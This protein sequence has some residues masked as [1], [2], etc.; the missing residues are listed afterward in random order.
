MQIQSQ[1]RPPGPQS[2]SYDFISG[3]HAIL[4][5]GDSFSGTVHHIL[6]LA[7]GTPHSARTWKACSPS[8]PIG[9]L[10]RCRVAWWPPGKRWESLP[11]VR[12]VTPKGASLGVCS[13]RKHLGEEWSGKLH[14]PHPGCHRRKPLP[15]IILLCPW[16][17]FCLT[18]RV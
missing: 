16:G 12:N 1:S 18:A 9:V 7:R 3:G 5:R 13:G 8:E 4:S 11:V 2:C 6:S 15:A 10:L 14:M 17:F